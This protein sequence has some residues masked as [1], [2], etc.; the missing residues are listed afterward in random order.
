MVETTAASRYDNS[1]SV[2][3]WGNK[4]N[5]IN[6]NNPMR[7]GKITPAGVNVIPNIIVQNKNCK[8]VNLWIE[9]NLICFINGNS[10]LLLI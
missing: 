4:Y 7:I 5:R 2:N 6:T 3:I 8:K 9:F 1:I 10:S